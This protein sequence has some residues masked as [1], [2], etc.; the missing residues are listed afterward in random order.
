M[1]ATF[2]NLFTI[3]NPYTHQGLSN[4]CTLSPI[5]SGA[6]V[7]LNKW[8]CTDLQY[9]QNQRSNSLPFVEDKKHSKIRLI[10]GKAKFRHLNKLTCKGTLRLV[11]ISLR[12]KTPYP[13]P[14]YALYTCIQYT[15]SHREWGKVEPERRLEGQQFAKLGRKYQHDWLDLQ[16]LPRSLNFLNDDIFP[17]CL[18]SF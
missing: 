13:P 8:S 10:E 7:P 18:Y 15:Y 1:R 17:W 16:H 4:H 14:P 12:P 6:T 2:K 5:K 3:Y 11:F 9:Q